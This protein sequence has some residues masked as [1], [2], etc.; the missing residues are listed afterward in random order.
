MKD[1]WIL[2]I[3]PKNHLL[4]LKLKEVWCY[5]DLLMLFI[6]RDFVTIYKQTILGP[7]WFFIQPIF[8]TLMFT[9]VFGRLAKIP[10]DGLPHGLFYLSGIVA[11]NYFAECFKATSG[12]FVTNANIFGKVYFPRVISPLSIIIS[13]L[14]TFGVQF[15]LFLLIYFF[16]LFKGV[17]I[18][19][20]HILLLLPFLIFM[21]A[22]LSLG[23]G[24]L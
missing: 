9:V 21:I 5:R 16:Y 13:K 15:T 4:D 20:N 19:P 12:T 1:D 10:T 7:L 3:K 6:R 24:W 2:V 22:G 23:F 8:T 17:S 14:I 11:W 18:H